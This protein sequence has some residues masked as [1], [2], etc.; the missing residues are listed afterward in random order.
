MKRLYMLLSLAACIESASCAM[1]ETRSPND[2]RFL[3][4]KAVLLEEQ[5]EI[6]APSGRPSRMMIRVDFT[7]SENLQKIAKEFE[8]NIGNDTSFCTNGQYD[9]AMS[10][11]WLHDVYDK[12]GQIEAYRE[13]ASSSDAGTAPAITYHLYFEVM[14]DGKHY[15]LLEKN[16]KPIAYDLRKQPADVCFWIRG[17]NMVGDH[18]RSNT[19][20]V[21]AAELSKA[22]T[23]AGA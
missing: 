12:F 13:R 5:P 14:S 20:V 22:I 4:T 2:L 23:A 1:I 3:A 18:F 19:V 15:V 9:D 6:G 16:K 7:T 21:P 11:G 17:G 8:Y 10:F